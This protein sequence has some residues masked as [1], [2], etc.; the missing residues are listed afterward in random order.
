MVDTLFVVLCILI[1][2]PMLF[3]VPVLYGNSSKESS[4][5]DTL[6]MT[7]VGLF[8][9]FMAWLLFG[10]VFSFGIEETLFSS[11]GTYFE[12][13]QQ[14]NVDTLLSMILQ[15]CFFLYAAGM[16]IGTLIHKVDWKFFLIFIPIWLLVVYVPVVFSFWNAEGFLNQLG[17]LDFSGGLVVHITAGVTSLLLAKQFTDEPV[18]VLERHSNLPVNYVATTL[19]CFGWFGF[20]LGPL[21]SVSPFIGLVILNTILAII[22][23]SLGYLL[24]EHKSVVSEDLLTGMM[25]GLVTS[26]A[27]VGY[28]SPF[29]VLLTSI[30]SG[31]I[32]C[33]YRNQTLIDDPVD[34]F[35]LNGIGG[36]IGT[37]G[38][39]LFADP[40]FTP[41]GQTGLF[42]GGSPIGFPLIEL[43]GLVFTLFISVIG[44]QIS[45]SLTKLVFSRKKAIIYEN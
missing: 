23:G 16:F 30:I 20:N 13:L 40:S 44:A 28:A 19:I 39:I 45:I 25:V 18:D 24:L 7:S 41:N 37:L 1:M 21:G 8:T 17:A 31:L 36:I 9:A 15:G 22:G 2:W 26:T 10:Y 34:S 12:S 32:T 3:S 35:I 33:Y 38:L 14:G 29:A 4:I 42:L 43:S 5:S 11:I 6:T 27:L